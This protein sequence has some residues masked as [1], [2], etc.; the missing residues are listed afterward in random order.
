[1]AEM[2]YSPVFGILRSMLMFFFIFFSTILLLWRPPKEPP[3]LPGSLLLP[4]LESNTIVVKHG[5]VYFYLIQ[6]LT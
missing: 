5:T 1:M 6:H 3:I 2:E 4:Q